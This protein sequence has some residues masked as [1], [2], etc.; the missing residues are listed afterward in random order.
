MDKQY[1]PIGTHQEGE[2]PDKVVHLHEFPG[3]TP[4]LNSE[5]RVLEPIDI[6]IY[7]KAGLVR[8]YI[9]FQDDNVLVIEHMQF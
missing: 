7:M 5:Q 8:K 6:E 3:D 1:R 4:S 2:S 9:A